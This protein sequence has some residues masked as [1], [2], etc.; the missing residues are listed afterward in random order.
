MN[1]KVGLK[2]RLKRFENDLQNKS[3][4]LVS[5]KPSAIPNLDLIHSMKGTKRSESVSRRE[6]MENRLLIQPE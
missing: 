1:E 6:R 4:M 2:A 5:P 3:N